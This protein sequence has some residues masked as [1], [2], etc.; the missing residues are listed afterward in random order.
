ME[1]GGVGGALLPKA[2]FA[3]CTWPSGEKET[4]VKD[5]ETW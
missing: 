2:S 4:K 3:A 1:V 5:G